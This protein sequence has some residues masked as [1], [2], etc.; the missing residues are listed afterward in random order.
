MTNMKIIAISDT[1]GLHR[2]LKIPSGDLLI[3]AGDVTEFGQDDELEDFLDWFALQPC[4]YK[5]FVAGN[6]DLFL[7]KPNNRK[8][9]PHCSYPP[10]KL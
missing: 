10:K 1:H 5:V 7:E 2:N 8:F 6:H 4:K 3:H 9:N